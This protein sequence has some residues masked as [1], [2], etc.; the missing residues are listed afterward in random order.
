M[1]P[2]RFL[3]EKRRVERQRSADALD[4]PVESGYEI[5]PTH[6]GKEL[7]AYLASL[8]ADAPL[9]VAPMTVPTAPGAATNAPATNAPAQ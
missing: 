1:P 8:Q 2:Y 9:F 3:F 6:E 5:V 7:A 4:L